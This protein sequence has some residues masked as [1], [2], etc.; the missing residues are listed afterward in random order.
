MCQALSAVKPHAHQST[1]K[2]PHPVHPC[3]RAR[4]YRPEI[5]KAV[6]GFPVTTPAG[7]TIDIGV[8]VGQRGGD[9]GGTLIWHLTS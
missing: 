9:T 3:W 2:C 8:Q 5:T 6:A 7:V 4:R 1:R